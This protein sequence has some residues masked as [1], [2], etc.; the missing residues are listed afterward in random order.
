ML[1]SPGPGMMDMFMGDDGAQLEI[2]SRKLSG[3]EP[4]DEEFEEMVKKRRELQRK[5][6][7][8]ELEMQLKMAEKGGSDGDDDEDGDF[9]GSGVTFSGSL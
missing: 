4:D 7:I 2:V 8:K 3:M 9:T 6:K 5:V 1:G